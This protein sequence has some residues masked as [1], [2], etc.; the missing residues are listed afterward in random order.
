MPSK[1]KRFGN[2][3]RLKLCSRLALKVV[4]HGKRELLMLLPKEEHERQEIVE[5]RQRAPLFDSGRISA[6][7]HSSPLQSRKLRTE[8]SGN[9]FQLCSRRSARRQKT[10]LHNVTNQV[11][12]VYFSRLMELHWPNS[13]INMFVCWFEFVIKLSTCFQVLSNFLNF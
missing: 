1:H 7:L 6:L 10:V 12:M 13:N 9:A 11:V 3:S 2:W 8:S 5:G 4:E